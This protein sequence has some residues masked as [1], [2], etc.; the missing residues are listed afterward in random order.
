MVDKVEKVH[1]KEKVIPKEQTSI[2]NNVVV[3]VDG[4]EGSLNAVELVVQDFHRKCLDKLYIVHISDPK[5]EH[6]RGIQYHS[7]TIFNSYEEYLKTHL[8]AEDYEIIFEESKSEEGL[9]EQMNEIA[10]SKNA[11]LLVLGFRGYN[12]PKNRPDE[13]S[14]GIKFLVHKPIIPCLIVKEKIHREYRESNGFKWLVCIESEESKSFK[15]F[16]HILR[17]VDAENDIVHGFTV[18]TKNGHAQKVKVVFED[19]I[20]KNEIAKSEFS[21]VEFE[22]GKTIKKTIHDWVDEHLKNENHFIDFIVLGYNPQKYNFNKDADNTTVDI[23][24]D[25][26]TNIFFDH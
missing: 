20:K 22:E 10:T 9:F 26:N 3:G 2:C 14:K 15:A 13:L 16:Q 18:D 7:K 8:R 23:I 6:D 25:I 24:K 5:K 1:K 17:Y 21:L 19:Y 4:S 12:G 11:D